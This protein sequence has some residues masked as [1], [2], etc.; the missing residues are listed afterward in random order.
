MENHLKAMLFKR[1][2]KEKIFCIGQN[3]TGT[4]SLKLVLDELGYVVGNQEKAEMLVK[5][6]LKKE[7]K[8][9]IDYCNTAEAFQDVP[10]SLPFIWVIL[11]KHFPKA[12]FILTIRNEDMWYN[13]ITNFHSNKFTNGLRIPDKKDLELASYRYIGYMWDYNRAAFDTPEDDI[14]KK[15]ILIE[16]YNRHN[17][18]IKSYFKND[19][20]FITI[21]V[22]VK[23]D[24]ENLCIFLGKEPQ[25]S[26]FPHENKT[27]Q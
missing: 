16:N 27:G 14:Y 4:T 2:N 22:S 9:T 1:N 10:F 20:N 23:K 19:P 7:Y 5:D 26:C 13:S 11:Q 17:K 21:D 8:S 18:N 3:K 6:Y 24:Y 25:R 15:D 12:K